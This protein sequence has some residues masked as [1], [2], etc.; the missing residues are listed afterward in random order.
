MPKYLHAIRL[1]CNAVR[2]LGA[3]G[4]CMSLHS[5]VMFPI[6]EETQTRMHQT[7]RL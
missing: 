3:E 7:P 4:D 2:R 5:A 1:K 6:H